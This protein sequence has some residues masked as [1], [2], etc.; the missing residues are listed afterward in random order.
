MKTKLY[1]NESETV[2]ERDGKFY[3]IQ[4]PDLTTEYEE[5]KELP[6]DM[7]SLSAVLYQD[8]SIPEDLRR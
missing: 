1:G 6:E 8:L 7:E 4:S 5:I 2:L 3:L